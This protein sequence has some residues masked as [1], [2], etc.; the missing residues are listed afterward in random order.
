MQEGGVAPTAGLCPS[1]GSKSPQTYSLAYLSG[2]GTD[3]VVSTSSIFSRP[4]RMRPECRRDLKH[5]RRRRRRPPR[6]PWGGRV[7]R[8][9]GPSRRRRRVWRQL[10]WYGGA[11][12]IPYSPRTTQ[13]DPCVAPPGGQGGVPRTARAGG[14]A[15][16]GGE[17]DIEQRRPPQGSQGVPG[18]RRRRAGDVGVTLRP[19]FRVPLA[20]SR[21][22]FSPKTHQ[23]SS[24]KK[25]FGDGEP[26]HESLVRKPLRRYC[27]R[28]RA[29]KG[30]TQW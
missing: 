6:S 21:A 10:R 9:M 5:R 8:P 25:Y 17:G 19:S 26:L 16:G 12:S 7:A 22:F 23:K 11:P 28:K 3:A 4:R 20:M 24:R 30:Q 13:L 18:A 27:K 29:R 14:V 2:T 1:S 15:S